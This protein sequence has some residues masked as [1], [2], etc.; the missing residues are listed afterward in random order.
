MYIKL[1]DHI[2]HSYYKKLVMKPGKPQR[3]KQRSQ[4]LCWK[5]HDPAQSFVL[6]LHPLAE[7]PSRYAYIGLFF[8]H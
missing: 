3:N 6:C 1:Y 4:D 8:G 2:L 5:V 7:L